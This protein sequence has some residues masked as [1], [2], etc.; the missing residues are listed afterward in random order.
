MSRQR[1]PVQDGKDVLE[2]SLHAAQ[3]ARDVASRVAAD[4]AAD[5][6]VVDAVAHA[7]AVGHHGGKA[8]QPHGRAGQ[9]AGGQ[10]V[11]VDGGVGGVGVK[12]VRRTPGRRRQVAQGE[13]VPV[14]ALT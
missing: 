11:V 5:P 7:Q 9:R 6:V 13:E 2:G 12:V 3:E 14:E 4:V 10:D 8:A 1:L